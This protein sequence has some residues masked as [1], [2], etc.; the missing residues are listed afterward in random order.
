MN[1]SEDERG[2]KR[3]RSW[4]EHAPEGRPETPVEQVAE[5][6]QAL[7]DAAERAADAIRAD[8]EHQADEY[9]SEAQRRADRL[10][11]S[12]I[13]LIANLVGRAAAVR[14]H[15]EQMVISLEQ[16]VQTIT[17]GERLELG[18]GAWSPTELGAGDDRQHQPEP[19]PESAG[20]SGPPKVAEVTAYG[21]TREQASR[22]QTA[23]ASDATASE[24]NSASA[25][26]ESEAHREEGSR[27]EADDEP[28]GVADDEPPA[29][30]VGEDPGTTT[31][32]DEEAATLRATRLAIAGTDREDIARALRNEFGVEDP[33]PI[34]SRVLGPA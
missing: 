26:A 19:E 3:V 21:G 6:V 4:V 31:E 7:I 16:T 32:V 9:L 23:G 18:E 14:S 2:I 17:E 22:E 29:A 28:D 27:G 8:A 12:R 30:E 24:S 5:R 11:T 10:T 25:E 15:S 34:V 33:E 13:Q 1:E 20:E